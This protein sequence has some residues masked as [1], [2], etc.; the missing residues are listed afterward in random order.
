MGLIWLVYMPKIADLQ[1]FFCFWVVGLIWFDCGG[2][3]V[4]FVVGGG[5]FAASTC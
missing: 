5:G 3:W 4:A 2:L 1:N